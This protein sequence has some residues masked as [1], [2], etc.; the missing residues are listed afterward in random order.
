[1]TELPQQHKEGYAF[2]GDPSSVVPDHSLRGHSA[3]LAQNVLPDANVSDLAILR[4]RD[5][6]PQHD[7]YELLARAD[8]FLDAATQ[9]LRHS[10]FVEKP[11]SEA[12][13]ALSNQREQDV[14]STHHRMVP[15]RSDLCRRGDQ[16]F[17]GT[18]QLHHVLGSIS[19]FDSR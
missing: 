3:S 6:L 18:C 9:L 12:V 13:V 15:R 16:L 7:E 8:G 19:R 14:F 11:P 1:M 17:D 4:R 5:D 2:S 10:N